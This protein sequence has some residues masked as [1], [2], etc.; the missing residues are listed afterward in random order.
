MESVFVAIPVE[1]DGNVTVRLVDWFLNLKRAVG[2]SV[3]VHRHIFQSK[4]VVCTRNLMVHEFLKSKCDYLLTIDADAVPDTDGFLLLLEA[5]RRKDVDA[6]GGWSCMVTD[7]GPKPC[8]Q[9]YHEGKPATDHPC[10]GLPAGLHRLPDGGIGAHC[11]MVKRKTLE[12]IRDFGVPWFKDRIWDGSLEPFD[13]RELLEKYADSALREK[14]EA[15]LSENRFTEK[16]GRRWQ[17][18]DVWFCVM[19]LNLGLKLW[20]DTRVFWGHVKQSD[21][22]AEYLE[23]LALKQRLVEAG[24]KLEEEVPV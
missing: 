3:A 16:W 2:D 19:C 9:Q 10:L 18:Q 7:E 5:I 22:R 11:L 6:V 23:V 4:P 24:V 1:P 17:G 15:H 12:A 21:I 13:L 20:V 8:V 14:L